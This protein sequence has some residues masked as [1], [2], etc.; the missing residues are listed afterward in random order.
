MRASGILM[1]ITS[2]P[3]PYGI[4]AMGKAAYDFV[5]FLGRAG[6]RYWQI[7]PLTPTG[8][9]N[10]PY[11]SCSSYAGNPYL[12]DLDML[13]E[14]G[15]LTKRE[16]TACNWG[17][18]MERVDYGSLCKNRLYLLR[19]AF[20]RHKEQE[21]FGIFVAENKSWLYP[22]AEYMVLKDQNAGKPWNLWGNRG[23]IA[24]KEIEF[25]CFV[26]YLF[27]TQ[28]EDL[29]NYAHSKGVSVIGDVPIYVP[30]DSVE[31][32]SEPRWFSLDETLTPT[33]VAGCPPDSFSSD[34]QLWGN[35]LYQWDLLKKDSY[36]WWIHRLQAAAKRY[37]VIRL[38][39][40]RGFV[41]YYAVL[42]GAQNAK[43]GQPSFTKL[44]CPDG[45]HSILTL[46][47]SA[48]RYPSVM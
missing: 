48:L 25:Y 1:H 14:E 46:H 24:H 16:V 17:E 23:H 28:W 38:D 31:V 21:D 6:Q 10:S 12:I 18:D 19:K 39:H 42:Y 27:H 13:I 11:Q 32:W 36:R 29:R 5:D 45:R 43:N 4:G 33:V 9:G 37:D 30:Y 35:P 26:Q 3:G 44:N 34:G 8:F 22:Y 47:R 41:D 2:L 40:F 15:L 20:A 7:L